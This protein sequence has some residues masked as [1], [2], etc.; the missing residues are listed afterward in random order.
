MHFLTFK[1]VQCHQLGVQI[2]EG[3]QITKSKSQEVEK[4]C[5]SDQN[6]EGITEKG[7][8]AANLRRLKTTQIIVTDKPGKEPACFCIQI[9][10]FAD[11]ILKI[12][13]RIG[14]SN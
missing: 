1:G 6:D 10:Q 8:G 11:N 14:A 3:N 13:R 4:R 7:D 2:Q 9:H 5:S 12:I